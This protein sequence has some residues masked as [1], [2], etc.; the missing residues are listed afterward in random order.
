MTRTTIR[1]AERGDAAGV[2]ELYARL[3][4]LHTENLPWL[5]RRP[6][7]TPRNQESFDA[8]LADDR[9][10]IL[11]AF[12]DR[13]I[14]FLHA[15]LSPAPDLPLFTPQVRCVVDAVFVD[16]ESRREGIAMELLRATEAWAKERGAN[17]MDLNVYDFNLTARELFTAA[18]YRPLSTRMS[19][20]LGE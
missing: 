15:R 19:K 12:R 16:P 9:A 4:D 8:V 13:P 3:D 6:R 10:T 7:A 14:G 18:G 1:A 20:P 5:L 2:N 11:V 17:G